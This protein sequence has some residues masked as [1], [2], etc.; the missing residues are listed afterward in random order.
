MRQRAL[1]AVAQVEKHPD[2]A[3]AREFLAA[4]L[5]Q[6]GEVEQGLRQAK[7][8]ENLAPDDGRTLY[9]VACAYAQAGE[10]EKAVEMLKRATALLE[11]FIRDWPARDPDLA[12]LRDHPEFRRM[13]IEPE[14]RRTESGK[15]PPSDAGSR[16]R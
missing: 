3:L 7:L 8:A 15:S 12:A 4:E 5:I 11:D 14:K 16:E 13:F 9:N 6:V 1:D 2:D 10:M